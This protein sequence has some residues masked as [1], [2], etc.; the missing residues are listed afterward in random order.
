MSVLRW[1]FG[2][3]S[4]LIYIMPTFLLCLKA[5]LDGVTELLV[6]DDARWYFKISCSSCNEESENEVYFTKLDQ[7]EMTGSRGSA[8]FVFKCKFCKRESSVDI[9]PNSA[10]AYTAQDSGKFKPFISLECRG[11]EPTVWIP[12]DGFS[13]K[14][15]SSG[16]RFS[17]VDLTAGDWSDFDE[18]A[19]NAVGIYEVQSRFEKSRAR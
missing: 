4:F 18:S 3:G 14:G 9:V 7:M 13:L 12:R 19:G 1:S 2:S 8:N 16:T 15:E 10:K 17:D 5:D 11:C 6:E